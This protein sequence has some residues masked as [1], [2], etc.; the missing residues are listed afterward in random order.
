MAFLGTPQF[1]VPILKGLA[2]SQL[3]EITAVFTQPDKPV[4]RKATLTAPAV[5]EAAIEL[6][7]K[8]YQ[9]QNKAELRKMTKDLDV[10]FFVVVAFGMIL[11]EEVL[12]VP[13]IAPLNIHASLLPKYRGASPIQAALLNGDAS[14]GVSFMKMDSKLDHGAIYL[15]KRVEIEEKDDLTSLTEKLSK[16][17]TELIV[18]V[19]IDVTNGH[20]TPIA[21]EENKATYCEKIEKNDGKIDWSKSAE[22]IHNMIRAYTPWPSA[23]TIFQNKKLKI[24]KANFENS[25]SKG[26]NSGQFFL[27]NGQLKIK[28][29]QGNLLPKTLQIEGKKEMDVQSF[30]NGYKNFFS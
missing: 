6:N 18:P 3:I 11:P 29:G 13:K 15:L 30:I 9:P 28:T 19:L 14:S 1:S 5:K 25:D 23:F 21:Q 20:L 10:D 16:K 12:K 22:E 27:D 7:L 2:S 26:Q 4:G 17:S 8:V 24:L